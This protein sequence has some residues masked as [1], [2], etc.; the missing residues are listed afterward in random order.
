MPSA[1]ATTDVS[2]AKAATETENT[3]TG[4]AKCV[5][6]KREPFRER[7][8]QL[9]RT[10]TRCASGCGSGLQSG[11]SSSSNSSNGGVASRS[12]GGVEKEESRRFLRLAH[13]KSPRL[14]GCGA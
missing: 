14:G 5:Y 2:P 9:R 8:L 4:R 7:R 6:Y 12:E 3:W 10:H 11:A 1:S 13:S